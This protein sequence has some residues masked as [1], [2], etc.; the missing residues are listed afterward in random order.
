MA[1]ALGSRSANGT[2][3]EGTFGVMFWM[4]STMVLIASS[5]I[6]W[7]LRTVD[8]NWSCSSWVTVLAIVFASLWVS[9]AN[10]IKH[11]W[12]VKQTCLAYVARVRL[13]GVAARAGALVGA[14]ALRRAAG[15]RGLR[16]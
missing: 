16:R 1:S 14:G 2:L 4:V 10:Y 9:T 15:G 7:L 11:D 12:D 6:S 5:A 3:T 8:R 13:V